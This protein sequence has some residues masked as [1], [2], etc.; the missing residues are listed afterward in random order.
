MLGSFAEY[1]SESLATHVRKGQG[2]R[3]AEG[4]HLGGI[5]FGYASCWSGSD[6]GRVLV[7]DPEHT[8]GVHLIDD[9]GRAVAE[10]FK[11][12]AAGTTT[13]ATLALW[14]NEQGFRTRNNKKL[15]GPDGSDSAG[16]RLFTNASVRVILHNAFY[17]GFVKYNGER[18]PA[19]TNR[20]SD[21]R[22]SKWSKRL[23]VRTA[24][25]RPR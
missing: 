10:L 6:G 12:Y 3:A 7:C 13:T 18:M 25:V 11:R 5:P 8:G 16:P 21:Q 1:Y 20:S 4:R 22:R 17:A 19:S 24:G 23:Y 15:P 14:L 2:Q 9:E